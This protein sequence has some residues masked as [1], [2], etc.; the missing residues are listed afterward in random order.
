VSETSSFLA[1]A[2]LSSSW[3]LNEGEYPQSM[4]ISTSCR[5]GSSVASKAYMRLSSHLGVI[6]AEEGVCQSRV[7]NG[8]FEVIMRGCCL[9]T[10]A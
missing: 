3:P 2:I 7:V 10:F 8:G 1:F 5:A 9:I 4:Q 6:E